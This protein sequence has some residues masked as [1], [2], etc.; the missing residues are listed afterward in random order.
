MD[1]TSVAVTGGETAQGQVE[2]V[3]AGDFAAGGFDDHNQ[4]MTFTSVRAAALRAVRSGRQGV[5]PGL[6]VLLFVGVFAGL[7]FGSAR[8]RVSCCMRLA[9]VFRI[10]AAC[11]RRRNC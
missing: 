1:G 9:C 2:I 3:E 10:P 5:R 6:L 4:H 7:L 8:P 11:S